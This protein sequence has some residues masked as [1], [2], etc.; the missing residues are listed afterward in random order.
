MTTKGHARAM[1][2]AYA[3]ARLTDCTILAHCQTR[4]FDFP[5]AFLVAPQP[6][7]PAAIM[8]RDG[9]RATVVSDLP[10][11]F[12]DHTTFR[13]FRVCRALRE[14]IDDALSRQAKN[15]RADRFPL[16]LV[17]ERETQCRTPL[18]D[19]QSYLIDRRPSTGGPEG[20]PVVTAWKVDDAPW[21]DVDE[22]DT[23]FVNTALAAV[24]IMQ[25]VTEVIREEVKSSCFY[26]ERGRAVHPMSMQ[27]NVNP[28]V[29]SPLTANDLSD[30]LDGLRG[31]VGALDRA[32]DMNP[33]R[34]EALVDALK[35]ERIETE[36][37][38][39]AWYLSL[40]EATMKM[41]SGDD[42]HQFNQRHRDYRKTIGHPRHGTK[43]DMGEFGRLQ[44]DAM[45]TLRAVLTRT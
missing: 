20:E 1:M 11:Y 25:G 6:P 38:R 40:Y 12:R 26:D 15:V 4:I 22:N 41:L 45:E 34:T 13:H 33:G 17:I 23:V 19:G 31:L 10:G 27:A 28:S 8:E 39:R 35:L 9:A 32:R 29:L 18:E 37:Y 21:P 42:R 44:R 5:G 3:H 14:K 30:R 16:F 43:M 24:K 36:H 2:E 7:E